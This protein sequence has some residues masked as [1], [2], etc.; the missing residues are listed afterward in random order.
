M[1]HKE[2]NF[3]EY[4]RQGE[5]QSRERG[6]AWRT[7]IGLQQVDG[8]TTSDYLLETA[9]SHIEGDITI[10]DVKAQI[11]NYYQNVEQREI[12]S[13]RTEEADK[14]AARITEILFEKSFNFSVV[15]YFTI[16][17]RL[18][19]GIYSHAGKVREYNIS[20]REWVLDSESVIYG[21]AANLRETIE[22]DLNQEKNF[23]YRNLAQ[24][25]IVNH[26]AKFTSDLWQ[27]HPFEEG[28]T[29][30][31]ALFTIKYLRTLGFDIN[32]DAFAAHSWYFRNALVRANY[33]NI[34]KGI[35]ATTQ[36]IDLFFRNLLLGEQ[37]ELKNRNLHVTSRDVPVNVPVN[38]SNR[39][40]KIIEAMQL[41]N[42]VTIKSLSEQLGVS[43][44]T[45]KRDITS[46]KER[47]IIKREG[48]DKSGNWTVNNTHI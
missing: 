4:I 42:R 36:F 26:I 24:S 31:T 29:R 44:K 30:T 8:L 39:E 20:K 34:Q 25:D 40:Q 1:K 12:N 32:N 45:V 16:H 48:S 41:D 37:N 13:E 21:N 2:I 11:D 14:V 46:L 7:A 15:E 47:D 22:Y 33:K 18:F 35:F 3:D 9:C 27:I 23:D 38:L 19:D 43:D 10:E 5:P 28:N 6:I 17:K